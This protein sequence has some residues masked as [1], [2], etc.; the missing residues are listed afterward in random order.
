VKELPTARPEA[1]LVNAKAAP[2][3]LTPEAVFRLEAVVLLNT[4]AL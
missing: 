2:F 3:K 1:T 4:A